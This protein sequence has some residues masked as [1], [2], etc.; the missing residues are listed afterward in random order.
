[1]C[2]H[3]RTLV[4][5]LSHQVAGAFH[6]KDMRTNTAFIISL[7]LIFL[8]AYTA[9]SKLIDSKAFASMLEEVPLIGRGAGVV[10]ILLPLAELLIALLLLFERTRLM[11]LYSS[12]ILLFVFTVYLVYMIAVVPQLPCSCGGVISSMSWRQHIVFNL[13]FIGLTVIGIRSMRK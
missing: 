10:A 7:L 13:V 2:F 8:F 5:N 11:G 1:V 9:S 4:Y 3:S 12:L 6:E